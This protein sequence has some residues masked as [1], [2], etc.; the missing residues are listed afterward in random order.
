MGSLLPEGTRV[1]L[2]VDAT[3]SS[4]AYP[5]G[6]VGIV[7]APPADATHSYRVRFQD[8][9]EGNFG[10]AELA[11]LVD[12]KDSS[13]G[14]GE[15]PLADH[16]L[17]AFVVLRTVVGSRAYGLSNAASDEDVRGIYL[18]PAGRDWSLFEAPEQLENSGTP[19][20]PADEVFWE[21][22]KFL[23]LALK[24][25]PNVLEV[26]ATPLV[27]AST[28]LADEL[29][30]NRRRLFS[31]LAY[32]TYSGYVLSQFKRM[33]QRL[34]R[35]LDPK[36][37]HAMHLLRLQIAGARL[38]ET[39]DLVV[40]VDEGDRERLLEVRAGLWSLE[41]V[42][43]WRGELSTRFERAFERTALPERPDHEWVE[44]F[45][46][47]AR[48]AALVDAR[49]PAS[50]WTPTRVAP[51]RA[52][53]LERAG[54]PSEAGAALVETVRSFE[55]PLVFAT[56][57]GAHLYGF[58]SPDSDFD[59]RGVHVLP[60][61]AFGTIAR[62][63]ETSEALGLSDGI[64]LDLVSHDLAKFA[65]MLLKRNGY[66]LEQLT[67]PLVVHTTALHDALLEL[68]PKLITRHHAHHYLGFGRTQWDLFA[69]APSVKG[70]L[71][72]H[73]A[74]LTGIHL[75]RTGEVEAHLPTLLEDLADRDLAAALDELVARKRSGAEKAGLEPAWVER[76][77]PRVAA[78]VDDLERARDRSAL[79]EAPSGREALAELLSGARHPG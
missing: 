54:V 57:S 51:A 44:D 36:W 16:A 3:A 4:R 78:L 37:K 29:R 27:L 7:V 12:V 60:T 9:D 70:L 75:V 24:S 67:S 56:V 39:G 66:V 58:P 41:E 55:H 34:E 8:G 21:L 65:R 17:D 14:V 63:V 53:A 30:A 18:P 68:V 35:G 6:T 64:D 71:Y 1:V 77:E 79:P 59:L 20:A 28:P 50:A 25:N 40:E 43:R 13:S 2:R 69:K 10:R 48:R 45:L 76:F 33:R 46:V 31:R 61:S 11:R 62:P 32:Q 22:R 42:D 19:D 73:R 52:E 47:R 23:L 72:V 49:S 26:L 38:L 74:L 15:A 5:A